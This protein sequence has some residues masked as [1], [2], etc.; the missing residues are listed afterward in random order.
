[1]LVVPTIDLPENFTVLLIQMWVSNFIIFFESSK[2]MG[3]ING[4]KFYFF[5]CN[6]EPLLLM[7]VIVKNH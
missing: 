5:N 3:R 7:I 4:G 1:M 2:R 6:I